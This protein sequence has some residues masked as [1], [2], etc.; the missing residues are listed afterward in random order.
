MAYI[1]RDIQYGV[2]DK[3]T[4]TG[5]NGVK[6]EWTD[7]MHGVGSSS[8]LIVSVGGVVQ[9][10]DVAYTA[11][12]NVLT[13]T[14][15]PETG[16]TVYVVY[17]GKELSVATFADNSVTTAKIADANVTDAKLAD[18]SVT[19]AKIVDANVTDAKL[20]AS[21]TMPAWDGSALTNLPASGKV[22]QVVHMQDGAVATG[23]TIMANNDNITTNTEGDEYM[24]LA[25]TP[26]SATN[27]L[28]ITAKAFFSNT[29]S[30]GNTMSMALFQDSTTN[31]LAWSWTTTETAASNR[32]MAVID[33]YMTS[34][35]A[36]S[37]TFKIRIGCDGAG[38]TT[39]NGA[40][41]TRAGA[42]IMA[43]SITIM[44]IAV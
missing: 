16:D 29:R 41:S 39:F 28:L 3:Q 14:E 33:H 7:L 32:R 4:L 8:S 35:T 5:A 25:I 22:V 37:T 6:T 43:S 17:L 30:S 20:A 13:F 24:T 19:T 34:G 11:S 12:G 38:T 10:P 21:G 1:G 44:E 40:N 9:E 36:S 15:A 31:A 23:S 18:N 2:L 26:T 27:K 42:G